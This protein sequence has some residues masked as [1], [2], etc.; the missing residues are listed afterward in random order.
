[1]RWENARLNYIAKNISPVLLL[2][3]AAFAA[4]ALISVM[5]EE[6]AAQQSCIHIGDSSY[7]I[8]HLSGN[9]RAKEKSHYLEVDFYWRDISWDA[10]RPALEPDREPHGGPWKIHVNLKLANRDFL[11]PPWEEYE[12]FENS[13]KVIRYSKV[14]SIFGLDVY[15]GA[16]GNPQILISEIYKTPNKKA[17]TLSCVKAKM[18]E[19]GKSCRT[20]YG[21]TDGNVVFESISYKSAKYMAYWRSIETHVR[22]ALKSYRKMC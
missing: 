12:R 22:D 14:R 1:M 15:E 8:P 13:R 18:E 21:A 5:G 16:S 3:R 20:M 9:P 4:F 2:C 19:D 6:A 11:N 10:N 7:L 17:F